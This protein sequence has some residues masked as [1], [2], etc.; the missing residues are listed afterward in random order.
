MRGIITILAVLVVGSAMAQVTRIGDLGASVQMNA[1]KG[2]TQQRTTAQASQRKITVN[3]G[4]RILG[5]YDTDELP[6]MVGGYMS[7]G[8][9]GTHPVGSIYEG[10]MLKRFVGGDIVRMRFA[11]G[12]D[13]YVQDAFIYEAYYMSDSHTPEYLYIEDDPTIVETIGET[14][15]AGWYDVELSEPL[16]IEDDKCYLVGFTL[17]EDGL[18]YP[19]VTDRELAVK[20]TSFYGYLIYT[21]YEG[22]RDWWYVGEEYGQLCIQA[23]VSG[24]TLANDDIAITDLDTMDYAFSL[25]TLDYAFDIANAGWNDAETYTIEISVDDTVVETLTTPIALEETPQ[26][27]TG[28]IAMDGIAEGDHTLTVNVTEIN[29]STPTEY[30]FDD[31]LETTIHVYSG[32]PVARQKHLIE[33]LTSIYC[34]ACPYGESVLE[35]LTEGNPD[36]YA[37]VSMHSIGMGSDP[38]ALKQ[39]QYYN[40]EIFSNLTEDYFN[41]PSAVFSR[42]ML[43]STALGV[44]NKMNIS[45][46]YYPQDQLTAAEAINTA[47]DEAYKTIPAFVPVDITVD[48]YNAST[49]SLTCTVSGTGNEYAKQY[50]DGAQLTAY[51]VENGLVGQQV[52]YNDAGY[53]TTLTYTHNNVLRNFLTDYDWG[54]DVNWTSDSSYSNTFTLT[55]DSSWDP[56]NI[57]LVAFISGPMVIN[58][59]SN[60]GSMSEAYVYNANKVKMLATAEDVPEDGIATIDNATDVVQQAVYTLDGRVISTPQRGINLIRMSDGTVKKIISK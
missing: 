29:G 14:I 10:N 11:V 28:T 1:D 24:T 5:F 17:T 59:G 54:E 12:C 33:H 52:G 22:M 19:L 46:G 60:W 9:T 4:D 6:S 58:G 34:V 30:T 37:W 50:L 13:V 49:R 31:T 51:I 47:V 15:S 56:N 36:K 3:D 21:T 39:G 44:N 43:T 25:G 41:Y 53:Q 18:S 2:I 55:L 32:T 38:Y 7:S 40:I 20:Y 26:T 57:Y 27:I 45:I 42:A 16:T 8:F 23:V 48:S 35:Y